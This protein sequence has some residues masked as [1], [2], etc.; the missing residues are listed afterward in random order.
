MVEEPPDI[1]AAELISESIF[2]RWPDVVPI[3][4]VIIMDALSASNQRSLYVL[5]NTDCTPWVLQGMLNLVQADVRS[6]WE[7]EAW[8]IEDIDLSEDD[9]EG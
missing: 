7:S 1:S 8:R 5:N 6:A 9:D 4:V 3:N 2:E